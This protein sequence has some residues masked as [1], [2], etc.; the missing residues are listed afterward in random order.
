MSTSGRWVITADGDQRQTEDE[1]TDPKHT[2]FRKRYRQLTADE[3]ALHDAIKDKADELAYLIG[4]LN[5]SIAHMLGVDMTSTATLE[6][7]MNCDA[8]NVT[9]ALRHLEDA[10]YRAVKALT[11]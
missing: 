8:A 11:Q 7:S 5:P 3:L 10:V 1:V 4:S 9:L 2:M 6:P